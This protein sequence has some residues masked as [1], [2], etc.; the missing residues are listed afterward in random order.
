MRSNDRG[1]P[2]PT[3]PSIDRYTVPMS[4]RTTRVA[5]P[6]TPWATSRIVFPLVVMG[7][8]LA[9]AG[10]A[11]LWPGL[12]DAVRYDRGAV[13]SGEAW[14]LVTAHLVHLNAGHAALNAA[15][16]AIVAW[17]FSETLVARRQAAALAVAATFVDI[18]L[19]FVHPEITSYAGLSGALHGLFAAGA[20]AWA[21]DV[22]GDLP[23][24][25]D[26]ARRTRRLWGIV[27][28]LGLFAKLALET[29]AHSF[30]L[31]GNTMPVVTAA[32]R[33]GAAGGLVVALGYAARAAYLAGGPRNRQ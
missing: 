30:W 32:H 19:F 10:G 9:L 4:F 24:P 2:L 17:I 5:R 14:R 18:G 22:D 23:L 33:W 28:L 15:G 8:V 29:H 16:L 3:L 6:R 7:L 21:L 31:N 13:A 12:F 20:M 27:L 26:V 1:G 25:D 11:A